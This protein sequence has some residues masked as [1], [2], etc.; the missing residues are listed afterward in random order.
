VDVFLKHGVYEYDDDDDD[1]HNLKVKTDM[2]EKKQKIQLGVH[3]VN[4]MGGHVEEQ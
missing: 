3:E 2:P 4:P 1:A